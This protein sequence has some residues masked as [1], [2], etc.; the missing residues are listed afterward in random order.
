MN[1]GYVG[2]ELVSSCDFPDFYLVVLRRGSQV[3]RSSL[4]YSGVTVGKSQLRFREPD[5]ANTDSTFPRRLQTFCVVLVQDNNA[6]AWLHNCVKGRGTLRA[7][8]LMMPC[9]VFF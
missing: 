5:S 3:R 8:D 2:G 1:V 4:I 7:F 6:V 9:T